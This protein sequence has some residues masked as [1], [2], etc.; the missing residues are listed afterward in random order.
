MKRG[1]DN[2]NFSDKLLLFLSDLADFNHGA[3][4][5]RAALLYTAGHP[6]MLKYRRWMMQYIEDRKKRQRLYA[7]LYSLK[8]WKFVRL[9]QKKDS[10]GFFLTEKG[11]ERVIRLKKIEIPK[12]KLPK[13]QWLMVLFD[14]PEK[15][16]V[17]RNILRRKL[18]ELGSEQFQKSI[19]ICRYDVQDEIKV[20]AKDL[21]VVE[22]VKLLKVQESKI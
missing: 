22:F 4:S 9:I 16:R 15:M 10:I 13:D 8:K 1:I 12:R 11:E 20:F 2:Y 3:K 21:G 18:K 6:A 14:I 5:V 19:W 7:T 17:K